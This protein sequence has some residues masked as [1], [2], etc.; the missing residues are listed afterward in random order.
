MSC[1]V[2]LYFY[3][4]NSSKEVPCPQDCHLLINGNNAE[5]ETTQDD[6]ELVFSRSTTIPGNGGY[7]F[8]KWGF[9]LTGVSFTP[10]ST[11]TLTQDVTDVPYLEVRCCL[12]PKTCHISYRFNNPTT[13]V[14]ATQDVLYGDSKCRL[15]DAPSYTATVEG[16]Q[17][18]QVFVGWK[19]TESVEGAASI[20]TQYTTGTAYSKFVKF[21]KNDQNEVKTYYQVMAD[22]TAEEN[23]DWES[24][25]DKVYRLGA[26]G[27]VTYSA[28]GFYTPTALSITMDAV[29]KPPEDDS[30]YPQ[31]EI[32]YEDEDGN[33]IGRETAFSGVDVKAG[34]DGDFKGI[35]FDGWEDESGKKVKKGSTIKTPSGGGSGGSGWSMHFH[36]SM[37]VTKKYWVRYDAGGGKVQPEP[38]QVE[39]G[40]K[41]KVA[42]LPS[43]KDIHGQ[44]TNK[45]TCWKCGGSSYIGE[46]E[47]VVNSDMTFVASYTKREVT[48]TYDA[49]KQG[50]VI[51]A[52][53]RTQKAQVGGE[54][55]TQYDIPTVKD[56]KGNIVTPQEWRTG[57]NGKVVTSATDITNPDDHKVTA[58]WLPTKLVYLNPNG[59]TINGESKELTVYLNVHTKPDGS[60]FTDRLMGYN[61]QRDGYTDDDY[62]RDPMGD[63]AGYTSSAMDAKTYFKYNDK[64]FA[65]TT[66]ARLYVK[67]GQL[68]MLNPNGGTPGTSFGTPH[69]CFSG[70]NYGSI[71]RVIDA[72][73]SAT[74][75]PTE[76]DITKTGSHLVGWYD[77]AS[78][79]NKVTNDSIIT[80]NKTRTLYA[81]W[82]TDK[83]TVTFNGNGGTVGNEGKSSLTDDF[84]KSGTYKD[85]PTAQ[86][87]RDNTITKMF[88]G[89]FT[90]Q[91]GGEEVKPGDS[92]SSDDTRTLYA[93]YEDRRKVSFFTEGGYN[94]GPSGMK[95]TFTE[96]FTVGKTYA[97]GHISQSPYSFPT[98]SR[99]GGWSF[100]GW[101]TDRTSGT[102]V[103]ETEL[104]EDSTE[105][106]LHAHWKNDKEV[107]TIT[108][109]Y[110]GGVAYVPG[111]DVYEGDPAGALPLPRMEGYS[112]T[113]W[114]K[115][116]VAFAM[117]KR[118]GEEVSG[119]L[120]T[121][122]TIITES[123]TVKMGWSKKI[124][125]YYAVAPQ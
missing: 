46:E 96:Y 123:M 114:H 83:Q 8:E 47:V 119:E 5:G 15:I 1:K 72:E 10:T 2:R 92:V 19:T 91:T 100:L 106:F 42:A 50:Y 28:K 120:I 7:E 32:I 111:K 18:I 67:W 52:A 94:T 36:V 27:D 93:H 97:E 11:D 108:Y 77:K 68:L 30:L 22:I 76:S 85:M 43:K 37:A 56:S 117:S 84:D 101:F 87:S 66:T 90:A 71:K 81:R 125:L 29:W 49:G 99:D 121:A 23:T 59:G 17:K 95:Y 80:N 79:G 124:F 88:L 4:S 48:V 73:T 107:A 113:G 39:P 63:L 116:A 45:A 61:V 62:K 26:N 57:R 24:I 55:K 9:S 41:L 38:Q 70:E 40:Y 78:G 104:V 64:Q 16:K 31:G 21:W 82:A 118:D 98:P 115:Q 13:Q 105:V 86:Y 60:K 33:V 34:D 74:G 14:D 65:N 12:K 35:A 69:G 102:K 110:N 112:P 25:E 6:T 122:T 103:E 89:W 58:Y 51:E 44:Y 20:T 54:T 75:L 109:D 53:K 3:D